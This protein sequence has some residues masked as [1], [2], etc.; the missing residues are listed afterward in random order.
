MSTRRAISRT[1]SS[2]SISRI[3]SE[4]SEAVPVSVSAPRTG[5]RRAHG[6]EQ[7]RERRAV[8]RV[9]LDLDH[10]AAPP[11]KSRTIASPSPVPTPASL[12]VKNGSKR[13]GTSFR[14]DP[15]AGVGDAEE[16]VGRVGARRDSGRDRQPAAL[17]HRIARV[18]GEVE[19]GLVEL[20]RIDRDEAR[21]LGRQRDELDVGADQPAQ[22]R[23]GGGDDLVQVDDPLIRASLRL[24]ESRRWV[25]SRAFAAAN[26]ICSSAWR[27]SASS[28]ARSRASSP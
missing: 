1:L 13:R 24:K 17:G 11:T 10:A 14:V 28:P 8:R 25:R 26:A 3:V 20:G 9:G 21:L 4:R 12:V 23:M 18:D 2:S 15:G 19:H 27:S 16:R 22:H 7:Q 6:R 5:R